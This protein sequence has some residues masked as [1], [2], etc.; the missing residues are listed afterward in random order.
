MD[1]HMPDAPTPTE[2]QLA[3]LADGFL[4]DAEPEA[5]RTRA[6]ASPELAGALREQ[7]HVVSLMRSVDEIAAPP[8]LRASIAAMTAET[9]SAPDRDHAR[10]RVTPR[11]LRLAAPGWRRRLFLPAATALAG[12]VA[13]VVVII[14]GDGSATV[15]QTAHLALS[16]A[17]MPAPTQSASDRNL[18][19]LRV[20]RIPFPSYVRSIGWQ[21]SGTRRDAL[22]GRT[23]TTVFYRAADGTRVGY[24]IVS[25]TALA[26]PDGPSRTIGRVRYTFAHAGSAKLVTWWRDGRTCVIAGRTVGDAT[27]LALATADEHASA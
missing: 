15:G 11:G 13:A 27:L 4:P 22:D 26:A 17:T 14:H 8:S 7:T 19:D 1:D 16:A 10:H 6:R 18:L 3:R 20:G 23:V 24:A 12:V 9:T 21:A 5:L 2:A 25:G